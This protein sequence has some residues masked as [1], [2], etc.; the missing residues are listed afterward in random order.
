V[1]SRFDLLGQHPRDRTS[2]IHPD[3]A[4][5]LP[6]RNAILDKKS[7]EAMIL[8]GLVTEE[9]LLDAMGITRSVYRGR[10]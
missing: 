6:A 5:S 3:A 10:G 2:R 1:V 8:V 9:A 4:D 7:T